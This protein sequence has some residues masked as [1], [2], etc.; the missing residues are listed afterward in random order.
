[1]ITIC[2]EV[3]DNATEFTFKGDD[4]KDLEVK[5][6]DNTT[7]AEITAVMDKNDVKEFIYALN[8]ALN[9]MM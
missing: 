9:V 5:V 7:H 1:M 2:L 8:S 4:N 3:K 6:T